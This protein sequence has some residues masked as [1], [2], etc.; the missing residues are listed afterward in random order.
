METKTLK[1]AWHIH[2]L[3]IT[4]IWLLTLPYLTP[5]AVTLKS[6]PPPT[7]K[8]KKR[9]TKT[10]KHVWHIHTLSITVTWLADFSLPR[11]RSCRL[12]AGVWLFMFLKT[13]DTHVTKAVHLFHFIK[14]M[15]E[16]RSSRQV[17]SIWTV[18]PPPRPPTT[19]KTVG[20]LSPVNQP[21]R[22]I[23]ASGLKINVQKDSNTFWS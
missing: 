23:S 13:T 12:V 8:K 10:V 5:E 11:S 1:H 4:D 19:K 16:G 17:V 6:P 3:S 22:V 9:E 21:H 15:T 20:A 7:I 18:L 2:I 14:L